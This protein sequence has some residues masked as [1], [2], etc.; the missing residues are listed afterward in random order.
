MPFPGNEV[1]SRGDYTSKTIDSK[2]LGFSIDD[3]RTPKLGESRDSDIETPDL[4]KP[5]P[6]GSEPPD[7]EDDTSSVH[8]QSSDRP[9]PNVETGVLIRRWLA[10]LLT[11][12]GI[13]ESAI[14]NG[15]LRL[16]WSCVS[17]LCPFCAIY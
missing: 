3:H 16:R 2:K 15:Q 10:Y 1:S 13:V 9:L 4:E 6:E 7:L 14:A 5:I 11:S 8:N 17:A 12:A